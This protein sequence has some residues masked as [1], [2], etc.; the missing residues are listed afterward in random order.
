MI[1]NAKAVS[2][3]EHNLKVHSDSPI[4][5]AEAKLLFDTLPTI[6]WKTLIDYLFEV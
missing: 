1:I 6:L 3:S 2:V 4:A 5:N